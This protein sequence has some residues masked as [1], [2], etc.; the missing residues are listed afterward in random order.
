MFII[1]FVRLCKT[2]FRSGRNINHPLLA[3]SFSNIVAKIIQIGKMFA[4]V[5]ARHVIG[6]FETVYELVTV[7]TDAAMIDLIDLFKFIKL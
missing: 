3:K 4:Q 5:T 6:V 1:C 2:L 7:T